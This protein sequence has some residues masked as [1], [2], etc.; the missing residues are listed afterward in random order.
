MRPVLLALCALLCA[1]AAAPSYGP[2]QD[3]GPGYAELALGP[4]R[5]RVR[6]RGDAGQDREAVESR[7]LL[8]AAELT[9]ERNRRWFRLI[10]IESDAQSRP[11]P[12]GVGVAIGAG[13]SRGNVG[14]GTT[15]EAAGAPRAPR[16]TALADVAVLTDPVPGDPQVLDAPRIVAT[17]GPTIR[18]AE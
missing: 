15:W 17:L 3:G 16:W 8:R 13:P 14:L 18:G 5:W 9:L 2:T 10:R 6:Y 12:V 1:C 4:E 11:A 7:A